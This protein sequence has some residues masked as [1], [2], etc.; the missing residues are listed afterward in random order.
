MFDAFFRAI[1]QLADPRILRVLV[2]CVLLS[3]LC[4]V[5]AW[6]GIGW[7]L[8]TRL[9]E[10]AWLETAVDYL[11]VAAT[12]ILTWLLFPLLTSAFIGLFLEKI[13]LA[14]EARHYPELPKSPGL[15]FW[16]GLFA[17]LRFLGLIVIAILLLLVL[18]LF[19]IAYPVGYLLGNGYLIAREYFE[20]VACRRLSAIDARALRSRHG[21][22][23]LL[24]GAGTAF[25]FT[26]PVVNFI[27][28][29]IAT[30]T[31]VHRFETWRR[32]DARKGYAAGGG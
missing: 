4:F 28:P 10:T 32:A 24:L 27:A 1:G 17:S 23:L 18:L 31:M 29:V 11:S 19:P 21:V 8:T 3:V 14:V 7:L 25:L 22:E 16:A 5:A 20:L 13:A 26:L 30:A 2:Y 15:P 12:L 9:F 6:L